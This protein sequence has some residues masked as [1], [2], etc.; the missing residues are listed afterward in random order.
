MGRKSN[1]W[2]QSLQIFTPGN[3]AFPT[4]RDNA[5]YRHSTCPHTILL[6]Q[7]LRHSVSATIIMHFLCFIL[8]GLWVILNLL[9]LF[10]W[11][12]YQ[13]F[14]IAA[15]TFLLRNFFIFLTILTMLNF[16][17]ALWSWKITKVKKNPPILCLLEM[18]YCKEPPFL[19]N[20]DK[21][22]GTGLVY[23]RQGQTKTLQMPILCFIND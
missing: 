21:I 2:K 22:Q 18:A 17:L 12:F 16:T 23:P 8:E 10:P 14:S 11:A 9:A 1:P 15:K 3:H 6:G 19:Y 7:L 13:S 20:L 4:E 5:G